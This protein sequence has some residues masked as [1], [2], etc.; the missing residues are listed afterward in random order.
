MKRPF[1]EPAASDPRQMPYAIVLGA[2]VW[3]GGVASPALR[4]RATRAAELDFAGEVAGIVASGGVGERPPSEA[5]AARAVM[6]ELGVPAS[7]VI[8]EDRSTSTSENLSFAKA[9]LPAGAAVVIVTDAW[10]LPRARIAARRLG[11]QATGARVSLRGA[12]RGRVAR[13]ILHEIAALAWY[14]VRPM[15]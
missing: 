12:H 10:H 5:E 6:V 15:R 14:L 11:M 4:R 1:A 2:A 9:L 7:A 8:L 3:P 13:A